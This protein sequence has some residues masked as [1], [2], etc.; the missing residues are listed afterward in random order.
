MLTLRQLASAPPRLSDALWISAIAL[1]LRLAVVFWAAG[2]FPPTDDGHFYQIVAERIA[3][4]QGYTWLWPDGVV[5]YAAHYP[6]GYPALLGGVYA[7]L[8]PSPAVAMTLNAA[9]GTAA[10]YATHRLTALSSARLGAIL[11]ALLVALHPGLVF[12]TPALMTEGVAAALIVI[13]AW[14]AARA[15]G[16]LPSLL[17]PAL[18]LG[19]SILVRP[20]LVLAVPLLGLLAAPAAAT[21]RQRL[22]RAL[23]LTALSIALC[24]PWTARN[25]ARLESCVFVSANGGWNL[26]IGT[27]DKG[28]GGWVPLES[29]GVPEECRTVF[30]EAAKDHCFGRA[31]ARRI[32]QAPLSWLALVPQKLMMTFEYSGA[33]AYYL[34]AASAQA[35]SDRQK[36]L[37]GSVETVYQR[38]VTLLALVALARLPGPRVRPRR[39][40]ALA[41][42][43]CLFL[44]LAWM[45]YLGLCAST[46][47]LGRSLWRQPAALAAGAVVATTAIVHAA[48]FGAGRYGVV[49]FGAVAALA[50]L[51]VG[52]KSPATS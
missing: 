8:G 21:L 45:S 33:A 42:S 5:T 18:V 3:K 23:A 47:L 16:R 27:S 50:G 52:P 31:G 46:A 43:A 4:G 29:I 12:Y 14:A 9:I 48:F 20:Q 35:F 13:G 36:T 6:V 17:L 28:N 7:L 41:G 30:A 24:L 51:A 19:V 44:P 11:A 32:A 22:G 39:W 15:S 37:L 49:V 34:H 1:A 25:C 10:V 38:I 2:L 26:F 40:L